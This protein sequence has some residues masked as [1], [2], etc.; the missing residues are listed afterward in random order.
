MKTSPA[1]RKHYREAAEGDVN[2]PQI[3]KPKNAAACHASRLCIVLD[4]FD[5]ITAKLALAVR[6]L[7]SYEQCGDGCTCGDGWSHNP[8]VEA[9]HK[10]MWGSKGLLNE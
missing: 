9:L 1:I 4:D 2:L 5:E 10:I 3:A 8:A 6:T 7:E